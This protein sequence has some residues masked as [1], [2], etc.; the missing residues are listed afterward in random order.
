MTRENNTY[1]VSFPLILSLIKN[2]VKVKGS[3]FVAVFHV[4]QMLIFYFID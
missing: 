2:T 4:Q 1:S 3:F